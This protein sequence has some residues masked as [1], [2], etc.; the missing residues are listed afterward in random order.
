M[1][2]NSAATELPAFAASLVAAEVVSLLLSLLIEVMRKGLAARYPPPPTRAFRERFERLPSV[3]LTV[4]AIVSR[5]RSH[6]PWGIRYL[7]WMAVSSCPSSVTKRSAAAV[8]MTSNRS[9]A[10]WG[11]RT[12]LVNSR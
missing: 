2:P 1:V 3:S 9:W 10:V 4:V 5:Y 7:P 11:M 6:W 8:V 12:R